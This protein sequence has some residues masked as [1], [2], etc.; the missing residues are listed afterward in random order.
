[1]V[2]NL[3]PDFPRWPDQERF[4]FG[5][6]ISAKSLQD[7]QQYVRLLQRHPRLRAAILKLGTSL[8]AYR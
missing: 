3:I 7:E 4:F 6:L 8:N 1:M 5:E 2:L